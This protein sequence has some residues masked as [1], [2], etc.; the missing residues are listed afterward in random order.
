MKLGIKLLK[1][2]ALSGIIVSGTESSIGQQ[3]PEKNKLKI[4]EEYSETIKQHPSL[5]EELSKAMDKS[6]KW[7]NK[8]GIPAKRENSKNCRKVSFSSQ[9]EYIE[10]YIQNINDVLEENK[11]ELELKEGNYEEKISEIYDFYSKKNIQDENVRDKIME[12]RNGLISSQINNI[13][14]DNSNYGTGIYFDNK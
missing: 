6:I 14:K 12:K 7:Y 11:L 13:I 5:K 4:C 1:N 9:R 3:L 2:I 10:S 8:Q